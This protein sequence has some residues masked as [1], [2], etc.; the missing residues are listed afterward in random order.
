M[1]VTTTERKPAAERIAVRCVDSDVHPV[2]K[3]G[4][5]TQYIPEPW[6]SKYFLDPQDRRPDLLRRA[7]LRARLRDAGGHV[8]CR[9]R[10][11]GQ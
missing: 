9:R 7:G 3:S 10:V 1:T 2:P 6:R 5:L 8:P 11:R 4:V